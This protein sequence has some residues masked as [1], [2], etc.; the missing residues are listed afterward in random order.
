M[1]FDIGTLGMQA[2]SGAV[3]AG[4]GLLLE[5]HNDRRQ[6]KQQGKLQ[7]LEIK[8]QKEMGEF[9]LQQQMKLWELTNYKAQAEQLEKAGLNRALL[10]G[11]SGGGGQTAAANTGNVSGGS[12]E[13]QSGEALAG[14]GMGM[15]LGMMAAQQELIKAQAENLKADTENKRGVERSEGEA[16]IES[17]GQGISNAIIQGRIMKLEEQMKGVE[18]E[19]AQGTKEEKIQTITHIATKLAAEVTMAEA[20]N[21]IDQ[22]T[23]EAK[24]QT[25]RTQAIGALLQNLMAKQNIKASQAQVRKWAVD[26]AQG[27]ENLSQR[28]QEIQIRKFEAEIKAN[29]PGIGNTLGRLL[30]DGVEEIFEGTNGGREKR[31]EVPN[32]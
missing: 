29:Y 32:K 31:Q 24:I 12:A 17:I 8:G 16:R 13:G 15:Q 28:G 6:L 30:N 18:T 3:G 23:K 9:N 26:I 2:A 7:E 19:I 11:M 1:P 4:M 10:Y 27:W 25:I 21:M 5:D 14:G 20:Q 22:A